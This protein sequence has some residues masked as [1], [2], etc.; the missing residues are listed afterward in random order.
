MTID[1]DPTAPDS[2]R[3]PPAAP[4]TVLSVRDAGPTPLPGPDAAPATEPA[5]SI[6]STL[7]GQEGGLPAAARKKD[8]AADVQSRAADADRKGESGKSEPASPFASGAT[9]ISAPASADG[10]SAAKAVPAAAAPSPSSQ[11][12][13][14]VEVRRGGFVPMVLG[15]IIAAGLGAGAAWWAIPRLPAAWQPPAAA[16]TPQPVDSAALLDQAR[17]AAVEAARE[18]AAASAPAN[19]VP[20][21]AL[22]TQAREAGAEAARKLIAESP[23]SPAPDAGI[24][25]TLAAQAEQL[26][27]LDKA[28]NDLRAQDPAVAASAED[29]AQLRAQLDQQAAD[30]AALAQR[31][32][33]D[34]QVADRLTAMAAAAEAVQGRIAAA[35][36]QAEARLKAVESQAADVNAAAEEA[37]RR[38]R[39]AAATAALAEALQTGAP[40]EAA[41]AELAEAGVTPDPALAAPV[42][43]LDELVAS[44]DP[45]AREAVRAALRAESAQGQGSVIGNFLR[46]QTGARSV[47]P[48]EGA[49]A[50]AVLS[51]AGDAVR[52]GDIPRALEELDALP[53]PARPAMADWTAKARAWADAQAA[54]AAL[55]APAPADSAADQATP[56]ESDQPPAAPAAAP[57]N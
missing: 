48:R 39:A 22:L 15:G 47:A 8:A 24:Q 37:A 16:N 6:D 55:A 23:A 53:E 44:F 33:L 57:S 29:M 54:L 41:L 17:A 35:A 45:A 30:L 12:P 49:D 51:R 31:P 10:G 5:P 2:P 43:T 9:T 13:R 7:V 27:A 38:A 25:T 26:A 42:P 36:E 50:D 11:P 21:E 4:G 1:S 34:P 14:V 40:H 56:S 52:H 19:L 28:L 20:D 46:A 32:A 18:A 3:K